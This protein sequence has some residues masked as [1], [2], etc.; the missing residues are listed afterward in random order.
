[1]R[2]VGKATNCPECRGAGKT[3]SRRCPVCD[4]DGRVEYQEQQGELRAPAGSWF[5]TKYRGQTGYRI[6]LFGTQ[7][8]DTKTR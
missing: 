5:P 3:I 2:E 7:A 1:M 8:F 6:V 4:G